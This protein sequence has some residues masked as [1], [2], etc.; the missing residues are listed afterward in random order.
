M[1]DSAT[2]LDRTLPAW[3]V[4]D[5]L[6]QEAAASRTVPGRADDPVRRCTPRF[7]EL[8]RLE[9]A[10]THRSALHS[11][12]DEPQ[13][14]A[15]ISGDAFHLEDVLM[16]PCVYVSG[17]TIHL[18]RHQHARGAAAHNPWRYDDR[19][20]FAQYPECTQRG[21]YLEAFDDSQ[22]LR[23]ATERQIGRVS[24]LTG[25]TL[26]S[27]AMVEHVCVHCVAYAHTLVRT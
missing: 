18:Q 10:D 6:K 23:L 17:W 14:A 13:L 2:L 25:R 3:D 20:G 22:Y 26:T 21:S 16:R 1:R 27:E 9:D 24:F 8:T 12:L 4:S 19:S 7:L 11:Y 15:I 5:E